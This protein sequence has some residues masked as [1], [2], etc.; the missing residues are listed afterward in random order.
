M[1]AFVFVYVGGKGLWEPLVL[2]LWVPGVSGGVCFCLLGWQ[3]RLGASVFFYFAGGNRSLSLSILRHS[4][5]CIIDSSS[6]II[7]SSSSSS[8]S[9]LSIRRSTEL[10]MRGGGSCALSVGR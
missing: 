2:W 3:G 6:I 8:S 9:S 1:G 10:C 4:I 7:S 5:I